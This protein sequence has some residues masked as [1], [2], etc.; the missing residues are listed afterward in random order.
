MPKIAFRFG[1]PSDFE[2]CT[3][4]HSFCH[5][6]DMVMLNA[7]SL[8]LGQNWPQKAP[9]IKWVLSIYLV[10]VTGCGCP[11]DTSVQSTEAPTE[12]AAEILNPWLPLAVPKIAFR[13]GAPSNFDRCAISHSLYRPLDAVMLNAWSLR[14]VTNW[15]QKKHPLSSECFQF[16]W[17][18]Y[19]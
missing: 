17:C 7:W 11:V 1:V 5:P 13:L 2:R 19:S 4:S 16:I 3:I 6:L 18:G 10:G 12:A 8:R 14:F 9:T 15:P